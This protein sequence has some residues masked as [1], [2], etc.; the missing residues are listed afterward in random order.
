MKSI[1]IIAVA[2]VAALSALTLAACAPASTQSDKFQIVASTN[3]WGDIAKQVG[4]DLVEVTSLIDNANQ[5]PHS[6][7]CL[8]YTS[9][10]ADE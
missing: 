2:T 10:A 1:K 4:G 9:D 5:D 6:Y 8:L 3:V 7:A